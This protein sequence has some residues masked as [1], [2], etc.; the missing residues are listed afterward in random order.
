[1]AAGCCAR[2]RGCG[3]RRSTGSTVEAGH[4]VLCAPAY[5]LVQELLAAKRD[6]DLP[7]ALRKLDLFEV[8][9]IDDV[10]LRAAESGRGRGAVHAALR[11]LRA[12]LGD[13]DKQ[14]GVQPVGSD[15]P[16]R[17]GHRRGDRPPGAPL[18]GA[19]VRRAEFSNGP[20]APDVAAITAARA[21]R[22]SAGSAVAAAPPRCELLSASGPKT[23]T[24]SPPVVVE[25]FGPADTGDPTRCR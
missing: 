15:L 9:L 1:M 24:E 8:I 20:V 6:L 5:A 2:C 23:I 25:G 4:S 21:S 19:R 14:P 13:G 10:W 17:D 16:R 3:V 22:T 12:P 18:G 7:R 11:A